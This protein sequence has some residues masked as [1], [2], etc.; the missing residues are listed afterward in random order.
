MEKL[1][2]FPASKS[3]QMLPLIIGSTLWDLG[4][5]SSFNVQ[6]M[7]FCCQIKPGFMWMSYNQFLVPQSSCN[8]RIFMV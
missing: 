3:E 2:I 1:Q 6:L 5:P 4:G 8:F 7:A